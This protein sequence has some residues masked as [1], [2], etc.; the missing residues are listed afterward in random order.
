MEDNRRK[1]LFRVAELKKTNLLKYQFLYLHGMGML[2]TEEMEQSVWKLVLYNLFTT[3]I[4]SIPTLAA[5]LMGIKIFE[6]WGDIDVVADQTFICLCLVSEVLTGF[7]YISHRKQMSQVLHSMGTTLLYGMEHIAST[8]IEKEYIDKTARSANRVVY[9]ITVTTSLVFVPWIIFPCILIPFSIITGRL[10]R[11]DESL[12]SAIFMMWV[13]QNFTAAPKLELTIAFKSFSIFAGVLLFGATV[14]MFLI[15]CI[16]LTSCFT[17]LRRCIDDIDIIFP[18]ENV[19]KTSNDTEMVH[20]PDNVS[21]Y[22]KTLTSETNVKSDTGGNTID[23]NHEN[24][25]NY[26]K[27][28]TKFHQILFQ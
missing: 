20:Q 22:Q 9:V 6:N 21:D 4:V 13:P 5:L 2:P 8:Y 27:E 15:I 14:T 16:Y 28:L 23:F 18:E 17:L 10:D 12:N 11:S 3:A 19:S 1:E 7:H 26:L 24:R 25:Y